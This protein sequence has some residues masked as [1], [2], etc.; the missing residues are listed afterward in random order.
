MIQLHISPFEFI[1]FPQICV[2]VTTE[3]PLLTP[4][5]SHLPCRNEVSMDDSSSVSGSFR[6]VATVQMVNR[7]FLPQSVLQ[8][9]L[10]C[11]CGPL[12]R[13]FVKDN[14]QNFCSICPTLWEKVQNMRKHAY[15]TLGMNQRKKLSSALVILL[16]S[17]LQ[18]LCVYFFNFITGCSS[19][20]RWTIYCV[21]WLYVGNLLDWNSHV[22]PV[23]PCSS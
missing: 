10:V 7:N 19:R 18:H 6:Y 13:F 12:S 15:V 17:D 23:E 21:A 20:K 8:N 16:R 14:F 3:Y 1:I 4:I 11:A 22:K 9:P 2:S 5:F